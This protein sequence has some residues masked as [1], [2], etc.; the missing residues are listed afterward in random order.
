MNAIRQGDLV[1][2]RLP[3][4][5]ERAKRR[6][7]AVL[8]LKGET[9]HSHRLFGAQ[10][11]EGQQGQP[12]VVVAPGTEAILDHPEHPAV[13]VPEGVWE[14]RRPEVFNFPLPQAERPVKPAGRSEN[15]TVPYAD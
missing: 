10:L 12:V 14:V 15:R 4:L 1:L 3:R 13:E 8:E 11:Y 6:K 5:P 9:G 7:E 2:V